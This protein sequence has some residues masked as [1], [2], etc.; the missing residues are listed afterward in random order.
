MHTKILVGKPPGNR[1]L[2]IERQRRVYNIKTDLRQTECVGM[3]SFEPS[4]AR[5]RLKILIHLK[6]AFSK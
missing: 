2:R 1:P 5:K 6:E 3:V 4:H